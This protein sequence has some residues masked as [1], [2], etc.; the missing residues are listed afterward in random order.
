MEKSYFVNSLIPL[1]L[2]ESYPKFVEFL[3][4]YYDYLDRKKGQLICILVKN[5]GKNYS[6]TPTISFF[7]KITDK[8]NSLYGQY[9]ADDKGAKAYPF[10]VNGKIEKVVVTDYGK[11]YT[12]EDELIAVVND[13]TGSGAVLEPKILY[14][15]DG[16]TNLIQDVVYNRDID[17]QNEIFSNFLKNEYIPKFPQ[18][19]TGE[20]SVDFKKF[21][22]FIRQFYNAAGTEPSY[23]FLYRILFN[24]TVD[25]YYPKIDI[26]K[27]SDG[28]WTEEIYLRFV[29]EPGTN[30]LKYTGTKIITESGETCIFEE[31]E[32]DPFA[33]GVYRTI[34]TQL[35]NNM[36][37]NERISEDIYVYNFSRTLTEKIGSIFGFQKEPGRYLNDDGHLSSSKRI[38]DSYYYQEFSYELQSDVS[39]RKY[40]NLLEELVHPAGLKY[41]FKINTINDASIWIKFNTQSFSDVWEKADIYIESENTTQYPFTTYN[42]FLCKP[43]RIDEIFVDYTF[44]VTFSDL[45]PKTEIQIYNSSIFLPPNNTNL[46]GLVVK[47]ETNGTVFTRK[48]VSY[49]PTT[50]TITLN[51]SFTPTTLNARI[52]ILSGF[53]PQNINNATKILQLSDDDPYAISVVDNTSESRYMIGWSLFVL[54]EDDTT[55]M[56]KIT[57]YN[58][59][60]SPKIL[61][62]NISLSQTPNENTIYLIIPDL[63]GQM[64]YGKRLTGIIVENGGNYYV[65]PTITIDPSPNGTVVTA[66]PTVVNGKITNITISNTNTYFLWI[67][68]IKITDISGIGAIVSPIFE[69]N[70]EPMNPIYDYSPYGCEVLNLNQNI[71]ENFPTAKAYVVLDNFGNAQNIVLTSEGNGYISPPKIKFYGGEGKNLDAIVTIFDKKVVSFII[72]NFGQ[73]YKYP[74][75][76]IIDDPFWVKNEIIKID[77]FYAKVI[78]FDLEQNEITVKFFP[79]PETHM[80]HSQSLNYELFNFSINTTEIKQRFPTKFF[81]TKGTF[82]CEIEI[83]Q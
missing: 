10:V 67:P 15:T 23:S 61:T 34:I 63:N 71:S 6:Q 27:C 33:P 18:L 3:R 44:P 75:F 48:I 2:Q 42:H 62:Y 39:I 59:T 24:T 53:I 57:S 38:Q 5:S 36:Y 14:D 77:D 11:N 22:K 64:Y 40:L 26:L 76:T 73:N 25:F 41:F 9:I 56:R 72:K 17:L 37:S 29:P 46:I 47:I 13:T 83:I 35:S 1:Y 50:K 51:S 12:K 30:P 79:Y 65:N 20:V 70:N 68:K 69:Q 28:K 32:T 49:N 8:N 7:R 80:N 21:V 45:T 54:Y 55:E 74:P 81:P 31:V 58:G 82:E 43:N 4:T 60:N 16:I 78:D 52:R 19:Y 66:T